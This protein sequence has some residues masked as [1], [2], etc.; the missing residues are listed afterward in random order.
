MDRKRSIKSIMINADREWTFEEANEVYKDERFE[1]INGDLY[2][3]SSPAIIHQEIVGFLHLEIGNYLR[4]KKG[5]CRVLMSPCD[6][7]LKGMKNGK[8]VVQPDILVICDRGKLK[9]KGCDGALDFVV[10]VFSPSTKAK[11]MMIKSYHYMESGVREYWMIDPLKKRIQVLIRGEDDWYST[12]YSFL[13]KVPVGI[14]EG[15]LIIDF[16]E[17]DL[18]NLEVDD[19]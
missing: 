11:D 19:N 15:D 1:I 12:E 8:F 9:D 4:R 10:E 16:N 3:M 5:K 7:F 6:V 13:D 18:D 17:L 14:Y 2:L